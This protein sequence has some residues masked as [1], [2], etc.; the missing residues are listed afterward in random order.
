MSFLDLLGTGKSI[1]QAQ[2][3]AQTVIEQI[4]PLL[5]EIENRLEGIIS[6]NL[7]RLNG[8]KIVI[9]QIEITIQIPS[10]PKAIAVDDKS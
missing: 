2:T 4:G 6:S 10:E 1:Q 3:A 7:D 5:D 8:A 9:P